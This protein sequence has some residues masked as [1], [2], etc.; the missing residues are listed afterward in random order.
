MITA[1]Y[2]LIA[3][4]HTYEVS[5]KLWIGIAKLQ[6]LCHHIIL[7]WQKQYKILRDYDRKKGC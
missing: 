5:L 1:N 4:I 7:D 3:E 6:F 2:G